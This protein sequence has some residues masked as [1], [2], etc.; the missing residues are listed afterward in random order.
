[1]SSDPAGLPM[2]INALD[3]VAERLVDPA[4]VR[5]FLADLATERDRTP[6][7]DWPHAAARVCKGVPQSVRPDGYMRRAADVA[8]APA[9][10]PTWTTVV[11]D[12]VWYEYHLA[13][14]HKVR[15]P[16][17]PFPMQPNEDFVENFRAMVAGGGWFEAAGRRDGAWLGMPSAFRD[18][19]WVSCTALDDAAVIE[20]KSVAGPARRVAEALG[21]MPRTPFSGCVR[22]SVDA[23][24]LGSLRDD[25]VRPTFADLGNQWFR[26]KPRTDRGL[27]YTA[28]GWGCTANLSAVRAGKAGDDGRPERVIES[29]PVDR[30]YVFGV[31]P[32]LPRPPL[33]C[34]RTKPEKNFEDGLLG[35]RSPQDVERSIAGLWP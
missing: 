22:Y 15:V 8:D 13:V 20:S 17:P 23:A 33:A 9:S 7:E 14:S 2:L 30:T 16:R 11:A 3:S 19:C 5:D 26:V 31:E 10:V 12:T 18:N 1:M 21:L 24:R 28:A 35:T 4:F 29:F 32:V 27:G 25:A 34:C 6:G